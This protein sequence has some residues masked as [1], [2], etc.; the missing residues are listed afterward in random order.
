MISAVLDKQ[1]KAKDQKPLGRLLVMLAM[2]SANIDTKRRVSRRYGYI[3][4]KTNGEPDVYLARHPY[5]SL[6]R[7]R[8]SIRQQE[9]QKK[10]DNSR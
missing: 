4:A 6:H 10:Q 8:R 3:T 2:K 5:T 9:Q 7:L 1:A